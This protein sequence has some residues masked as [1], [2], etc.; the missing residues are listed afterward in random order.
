M[1]TLLIVATVSL[2]GQDTATVRVD[3]RNTLG[4]MEPIWAYFG[5]DEPNYTYM[6]NGRKLLGELVALSGVPVYLRTHCLLNTGDGT[7]ALKWGSSNVYAED[8]AGNPVY[9]WTIIDRIFDT[10]R[11]TGVK[12]L[13][14]IGFMPKALSVK[15]EPYRHNWPDG[16]L[17]TG[18]AYPPKD[19]DKW[20][21][22]VYQW[23]RHSVTRYGRH[24]V[25]SWYWEA[26]NE[27]N[28]GYWQ[29][30][31]EEYFR[32][33]DYTARAVK[34]ALPTARMGGPHSTGP[35]SE[36]AAAFL[37]AFLEHC[38]R[39]GAPLDFIGFHAKGRPE[40]VDGHVRMGIQKQ[41]NDIAKGFEIVASFPEFRDLPIIIGESDPE[42]CA[43]CS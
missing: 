36:Q 2:A 21:E 29:G 38:A 13:V 17:M 11:D 33:Y 1:I 35:G 19:Y 34:R 16:P 25:E 30:A 5:H 37:R 42:G 39:T 28:I 4:P 10:Y 18:W 32:L 31:D 43:A 15:P 6:K 3:A 26:W 12:P 14:E 24:E 8:A 23:V 20:A 41:L 9:D 7:P 22:L 27:P 40:I